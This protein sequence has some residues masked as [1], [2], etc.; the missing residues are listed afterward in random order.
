MLQASDLFGNQNNN[1]TQKQQYNRTDPSYYYLL[2]R[3]KA[4]TVMGKE[5]ENEKRRKARLLVVDSARPRLAK[6][7]SLLQEIEEEHPTDDDAD[8]SVEYIPCV[9]TFDSYPDGDGN[10][11]RYLASVNYHGP[12]AT[13]KV[14]SSLAPIF[15]QDQALYYT[16]KEKEKDKQQQQPH[17]ESNLGIIGAALGVGVEGEFDVERIQVFFKTLRGQDRE[18]PLPIKLL[19]PNSGYT[20]MHEETEAFKAL[21]KDAKEEAARLHNMGPGKMAKFAFD[22]S[23]ILL[24]EISK[25]NS[26]EASPEEEDKTLQITT[27]QNSSELATPEPPTPR[28]IDPDKVRYACRKCRTILFG[29]DDFE[30]PPHLAQ[31]HQFSARKKNHGRAGGAASC[32]SHFLTDKG[33]GWMGD[34][35]E[36]EG[37]F[38]CP[39]CKTKLGTWHWAG[40]QCSCGTWVTP[41]VQIPKSKVDELQSTNNAASAL[42]PGTVISPHV[43]PVVDRFDHNDRSELQ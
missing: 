26:V 41:A 14:G 7:L 25:E 12:D 34:M 24:D 23:R 35:S 2:A 30:D 37:R 15:D 29:E 27:E 36:M 5:A 31:Q 3:Q 17:A 38:G 28:V 20:T 19:E 39:K 16:S 9:A 22:V 10:N 18:E 32:Q 1:D 42:P 33:L 43:V 11:V 6:V 13:Q 4:K 40:V 8:I 21:D